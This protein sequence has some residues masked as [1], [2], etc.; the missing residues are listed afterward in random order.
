MSIA[1]EVHSEA[2]AAADA[3]RGEYAIRM[4]DA[5]RHTPRHQLAATLRELTNARRAE[6]AAVAHNAAAAIRG[7]QQAALAARSSRPRRTQEPDLSA[8]PTPG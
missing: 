6:L 2:S 3:I 4:K 1:E 7:R 8:A 5:R